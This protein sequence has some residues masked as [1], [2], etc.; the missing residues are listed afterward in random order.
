M[1]QDVYPARA[2]LVILSEAAPSRRSPGNHLKLLPTRDPSTSLGM[3][4]AK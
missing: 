2:L 4:M 3:T 1:G